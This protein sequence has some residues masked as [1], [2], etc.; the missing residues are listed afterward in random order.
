[1]TGEEPGE[2]LDVLKILVKLKKFDDSIFGLNAETF[3]YYQDIPEEEITYRKPKEEEISFIKRR[4]IEIIVREPRNYIIYTG[5]VKGIYVSMNRNKKDLAK[6]LKDNNLK[7]LESDKIRRK[8]IKEMGSFPYIYLLDPENPFNH[9]N[10]ALYL[11]EKGIDRKK[12]SFSI[13]DPKK[14]GPEM[15]VNLL[16]Q[17]IAT[18]VNEENRWAKKEDLK[19][20]IQIFVED[21]YKP[22]LDAANALKNKYQK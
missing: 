15:S 8:K 19:N 4:R 6:F 1:M 11:E 17:L 22:W 16:E 12:M 7:S 21:A 5:P 9:F 18:C 10:I 2:Y 20:P 3:Y 14:L 13:K